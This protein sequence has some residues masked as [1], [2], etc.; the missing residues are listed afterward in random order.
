MDV[1]RGFR[2]CKADAICLI[3]DEARANLDRVTLKDPAPTD[4]F[5][6]AATST[7]SS[8]QNEFG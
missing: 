6:C 3:G 7:K 1:R 8:L 4:V 5:S 2:E